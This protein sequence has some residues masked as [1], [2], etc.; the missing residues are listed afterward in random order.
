MAEDSALEREFHELLNTLVRLSHIGGVLGIGTTELVADVAHG[1]ADK[2]RPGRIEYAY[3]TRCVT[4]R[5]DHAKAEHFVV[6]IDRLKRRGDLICAISAA[7]A[8]AVALPAA[9][10]TS[11]TLPM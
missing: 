3:M 11:P 7:P 8:Y 2:Q 10:S 1:V 9:P 5:G 6:V 4:W